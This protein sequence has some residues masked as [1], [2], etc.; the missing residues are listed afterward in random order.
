MSKNIVQEP[1]TI[2]FGNILSELESKNLKL[3]FVEGVHNWGLS[4]EDHNKNLYQMETYYSHS[5]LGRLIENESVVKF[6]YFDPTPPVEDW[7]KEVW[8]VARVKQ[9]VETTFAIEHPD[10]A[11]KLLSAYSRAQKS[12]N[13]VIQNASKQRSEEVASSSKGRSERS[14]LQL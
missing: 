1:I 12:L 2:D 6:E 4:L 7:E 8:D 9:Y 10:V 3:C 5:W 14:D 11:K 13:T